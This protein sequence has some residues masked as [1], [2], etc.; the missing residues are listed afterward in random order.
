MNQPEIYGLHHPDAD[1][2]A[3]TRLGLRV[4]DP[5]IDKL[6]NVLAEHQVFSVMAS[7][8]LAHAQAKGVDVATFRARVLAVADAFEVWPAAVDQAA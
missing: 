6:D 3:W 8:M 2:S 5:A 1:V 7:A 4:V